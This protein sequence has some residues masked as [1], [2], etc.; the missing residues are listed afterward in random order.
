MTARLQLKF[1]TTQSLE[2]AVPMYNAKL[3]CQSQNCYQKSTNSLGN[4]TEDVIPAL[5]V[6]Y[7]SESIW[8]QQL[9]FI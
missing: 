9:E 6:T 1:S 2:S 8:R 7:S 4:E 3:N 5:T